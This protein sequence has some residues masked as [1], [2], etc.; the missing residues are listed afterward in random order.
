MKVSH[1]KKLCPMTFAHKAGAENR[2]AALKT[3]CK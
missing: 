1:Q 3:D 2:R